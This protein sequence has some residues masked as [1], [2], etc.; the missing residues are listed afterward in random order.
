M[1]MNICEGGLLGYPANTCAN[2]LLNSLQ[3]FKAEPRPNIHTEMNVM[4]SHLMLS[5]VSKDFGLLRLELGK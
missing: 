5:S 3:R 4:Y 2:S 1:S